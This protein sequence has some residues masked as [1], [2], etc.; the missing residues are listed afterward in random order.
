MTEVMVSLKIANIFFKTGSFLL[1]TT[2]LLKFVYSL[3]QTLE[4]LIGKDIM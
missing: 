2:G 4:D 3:F 1:M